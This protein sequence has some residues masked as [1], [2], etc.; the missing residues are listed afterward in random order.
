ML[1]TALQGK[2]EGREMALHEKV[3]GLEINY[4]SRDNKVRQLELLHKAS[5]TTPQTGTAT[6]Q[7]EKTLN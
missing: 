6:A 5:H 3:C 4:R 2:E 7:T 1:K